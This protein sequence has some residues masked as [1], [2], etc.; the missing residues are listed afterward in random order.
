MSQKNDPNSLTV[1]P[2]EAVLDAIVGFTRRLRAEGVVVS[3]DAAI[4]ATEALSELDS[5]DRARVRTALKASLVSSQKDVETFDRL[6][7]QLWKEIRL[8]DPNHPWSDVADE[9]ASTGNRWPEH[10]DVDRDGVTDESEGRPD[11]H[12]D[13]ATFSPDTQSETDV[14]AMSVE[15]ARYSPTGRSKRVEHP[16]EV[17]LDSLDEP[18]ARMTRVLSTA[19]GRKRIR[20]TSGR[21]VDMRRALRSSVQ[22]GGVVSELPQAELQDTDVRG[23]VLVDVS[24]SVLDYIDRQF[25]L[26]W[27]RLLVTHW[28]SLRVFF[29][30]TDVREVTDSFDEQTIGDVTDALASAE[31][32]WGGGT[33]IGRAIET[34]RHSHPDVVDRRTVAFVVSDGLERGGLDALENSTIWLSRESNLFLWLNPLAAHP[35]YEPTARGMATAL[36]AVDGLF[37]FER[38]NDLFELARQLEHHDRTRLGYQFDPRRTTREE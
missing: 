18:V 6:F 10:E 17:A 13:S 4:V 2:R 12:R 21:F 16:P 25:L 26:E 20:A 27:L 24:Q 5:L 8:D 23:V 37:A 35:E 31:A 14:T 32:D 19:G 33:Q 1:V 38:A 11:E 3:T 29:F 28:R 22:T 9:C 30:D 7:D 36:S 15:R 34:I